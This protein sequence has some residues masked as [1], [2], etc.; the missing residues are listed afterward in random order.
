V[1][2]LVALV[3]AAGA[4]LDRLGWTT[5]DPFPAVRAEIEQRVADGSSG[6][7]GFTYSDPA[8]ST[9]PAETW[10]WAESIVVGLM[11]YL[12]HAG[13]ATGPGRVARFAERNHYVPL[14]SAM[15]QIAEAL[16]GR[17][18]RAEVVIDDSRLVDRAAAHR[19][20]L[21][22]WGKNTML[23]TPGLGPWF[24]IGCVVTDAPLPGAEPMQ[25]DCGTCAAC[26]PACPTGALIRPGV[27]DAR[28]CLAAILQAPGDIPVEYRV[29]VADRIYG[30]DDCIDACPP[31][32]RLRDAATDD[33]GSVDPVELLGLG[34]HEILERFGHFYLPGGDP[35]F[36]RRNALVVL[37]NIGDE[38]HFVLLSGYL[39]HPDAM[40]RS[41]AR[42]AIANIGGPLAERILSGVQSAGLPIGK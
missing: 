13:T 26:L 36:L 32:S 38:T 16:A 25:R 41:H 11:A 14:R 24:L 1:T 3:N 8:R 21:A 7:L 34:D 28:R 35:R 17:G 31:G 42:W 22:W 23:L 4:D 27:L 30:C 20:G 18:H 33:R 15:N 37:G 19:A 40:L 10:P 29:A 39:M 5:A 9:T 12:P 2:D 6:R